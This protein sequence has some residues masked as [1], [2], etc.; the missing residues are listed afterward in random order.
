MIGL[1]YYYNFNQIA[2]SDRGGYEQEPSQR[3]LREPV[4]DYGLGF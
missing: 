1:Y 2:F 4:Y 3:R